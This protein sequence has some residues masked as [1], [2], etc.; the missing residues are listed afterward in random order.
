[1]SLK[2]NFFSLLSL[3]F[4]FSMAFSCQ[5][6]ESKRIVRTRII[7][8]PPTQTGVTPAV[9]QQIELSKFNINWK[10]TEILEDNNGNKVLLKHI[11]VINE[12]ELAIETPISLNLPLCT[13]TLKL[14]YDTQVQPEPLKDLKSQELIYTALGF[15]DCVSLQGDLIIGFSFMAWTNQRS[16]VQQFAAFNLSKESL[17]DLKK[18]SSETGS[19]QPSYLLDWMRLQNF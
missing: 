11:V 6:H 5:N 16:F 15:S 2:F 12:K 17:I 13:D 14:S 9:E 1:M 18:E 19:S 3:T 7:E 4:V 10:Q 8:R